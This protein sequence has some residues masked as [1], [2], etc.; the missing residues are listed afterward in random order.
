[1]EEIKRKCDELVRIFRPLAHATNLYGYLDK[2]L[3]NKNATHLAILS[4]KNTID[5][6]NLQ[7][8]KGIV[9]WDSYAEQTEI[10]KELE[11]RI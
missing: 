11:S 2:E 4:T 1:M 7:K 3:E 10:L 9:D 6:L 8:E 5:L